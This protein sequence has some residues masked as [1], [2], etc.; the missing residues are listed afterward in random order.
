MVLLLPCSAYAQSQHGFKYGAITYADLSMKE[1]LRDTS[2]IALV[3][4][5]FGETYIQDAPPYNLRL[6]Y[7]V[8]IK[9]LKKEGLSQADYEIPIQ[10]DGAKRETVTEIEASTF[11]LE[12]NHIAESKV[13]ARKIFDE[14]RNKYW[15]FKK[16]ALPNVQVGSIIEV[17]YI[18][19]S[20]F[21]FNWR[22]WEFQSDIPKVTSEFWAKIPANYNYN[23]VLR[24]P[25][26]ISRSKAELI[27]DCFNVG[28]GKADCAFYVY[29][30]ND[31]PAFK[32]EDYMTAKS[33]FLSALYFELIETTE[34]DGA[35]TKYTEEWKDVDRKLTIADYFGDQVRQAKKIWSDQVQLITK[36]EAEPLAKARR[37][38]D[39]VKKYYQWNENFGGFTDLGA[40]KAYQTKRG[41]VADINLSLVGALQA[42]G[43]QADPVL[44]STR[45][46]GTPIMLHP[47]M[48]GFNYAIV[49]VTV[50][51]QQYW[52]DATH[53]LYAFGFVPEHCLNGKVRV[54]SKVSD[55]V[56]L[57][58]KDK[59]KRIEELFLSIDKGGDLTGTIKISHFGYDAF[60]QREELSSTTIEEYKKARARKWGDLEI[61]N[62]TN[63]GVDSLDKPLIEKFEVRLPE[64]LTSELLYFSPFLVGRW[65]KNPFRS[66]ERNYPVDF[67]AP[68]EQITT[69]RLDYKKLFAVDE[70]PK[71]SFST[72]PQSGG[73]YAFSV[74]NVNNEVQITSSLT[75]NK[76]VYSPDEYLYLREFFARI[77]QIQESQVV[78]KKIK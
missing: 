2:A 7:H 19:E 3:L 25:F 30:I 1:Y 68:L 15:S 39:A 20:P 50:A 8:K 74:S 59:D 28:A 60:N 51:D 35:K 33:N 12:N 66:S 6:E 5:E 37:V 69:V 49:R 34:F 29:A 42:A 18:L 55:W 58:P 44:L 9:I 62:Y 73:R 64:N 70:L 45:K 21:I 72:L 54:M 26:T 67:G 57:K 10:I 23:V 14:D 17:K 48:S 56:D 65:M 31:I 75:L 76:S 38:Y 78:L 53:P 52:L 43:L 47:V 16:F 22:T 77:V 36:D 40:K 13:E 63:Q 46:H 24:G 27:K 32:E 71:S 41:N 4:N 11:N 61:I